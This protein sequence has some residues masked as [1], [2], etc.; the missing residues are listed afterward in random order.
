MSITEIQNL[1]NN[2]IAFNN[3]NGILKNSQKEYQIENGIIYLD[4]YNDVIMTGICKS[5]TFGHDGDNVFN[6]L[7]VDDHGREISFEK[8]YIRKI[9][10]S[11]VNFV[12][13]EAI[14]LNANISTGKIEN[15]ETVLVYV[16]ITTIDFCGQEFIL[17][18]GKNSCSLNRCIFPPLNEFLM[19]NYNFKGVK[20]STG[21]IEIATTINKWETEWK[22]IIEHLYHILSFSASN[23]ISLP[24]EYIVASSG[25]K[26][27]KIHSSFKETGRGSSIFNLKYPGVMV[28][29]IN[30][31]CTNYIEYGLTLDIDKLFHYYIMMKNTNYLENAYL[32]GCIFMEGL[33]HSY[34]KKYKKYPENKGGYF[35]KATNG[36]YTFKELIKEVYNEFSLRDGDEEFIKYRNEV[37]HQGSIGLPFPD[38]KKQKEQLEITIEKLLL[39]IL[40][41][42]GEYY[43]DRKSDGWIKYQS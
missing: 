14:I 26:I 30:T 4:E 17:I 5:F 13:F 29:I 28:N 18:D 2:E 25:N 19:I 7:F 39:N 10:F 21:Y 8:L 41:I 11:D 20:N 15:N 34:A 35:L 32:L 31:I 27:I 3:C 43:R 6:G 22:K 16:I 9:H 12:E 24:I 33:K 36:K 40:G 37:I 38:M 42:K 23:F 1:C